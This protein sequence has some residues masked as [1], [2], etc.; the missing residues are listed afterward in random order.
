MGGEIAERYGELLKGLW[1]GRYPSISPNRFKSALSRFA[2]QFSGFQ[3]HDSQVSLSSVSK[4]Q[5]TLTVQQEFLGF[6]LDGLH[7]DLNLVK[8]KPYVTNES[9]PEYQHSYQYE[10]MLAKRQLVSVSYDR[11][12][13][14]DSWYYLQK[15]G[16]LINPEISQLLWIFFR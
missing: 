15:G 1:S 14:C 9:E 7:E 5:K 6:L 8:V 3:Q 16:K 4:T 13:M 12:V 2:P 11:E 10:A